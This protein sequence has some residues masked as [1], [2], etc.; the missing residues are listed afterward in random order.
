MIEQSLYQ[1]AIKFA[2]EK[3]AEQKIPGSNANYLLHLSTVA[4]EIIAAF[5]KEPNFN[6]N[7]ALQ[8]SLLHDSL[9][10]TKTTYN[11]IKNYFSEEIAIGVDALTKNNNLFSKQNKMEDSIKRIK[12]SYKEVAIVK[13]A[14]RITNL[15]TPPQKWNK[16][17][18]ANYKEEAKFISSELKGFNIYLEK[19]LIEKIEI[20]DLNQ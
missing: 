3:H 11:E 10:D 4:M 7:L 18:I 20:Y 9:E 6:L 1:K 15:Q 8:L 12:E 5:M 19:R 16:L 2:G 17:K 13:L 14:D